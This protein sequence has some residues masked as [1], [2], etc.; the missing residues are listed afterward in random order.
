MTEYLKP[1]CDRKT[2]FWKNQ[3]NT[4]GLLPGLEGSC[5][6]AT[7]AP[8]G[9]WHIKP[10]RKLPECYVAHTMSAYKGVRNVLEHNTRL[11]KAA[12]FDEKV[13]LLND[14]FA[15]FRKAEMRRTEAKLVYRIHWSGD[16]F[17][18]DY[19]NALAKAIQ[20]NPD[21]EFWNYTRSLF[22]VPV[23]CN[24]ENLRLYISLD[25]V[26]IQQGTMTY[27]EHK[28][29]KNHLQVCYMSDIDDFEDHMQ[30]AHNILTEENRLRESM[31]YKPKSGDLP[32]KLTPCPVDT[33][34]LKLEMGCAV[35]KRCVKTLPDPVFFKT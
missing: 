32:R 14:E 35:C 26:N 4:Y 24:I 20:D 5:P 19:A 18:M 17:D 21:I 29:T 10:G 16:I 3:K 12:S 31:G 15:R 1:T 33:G 22:A 9:C 13:R 28:T 7:T 23:L 27:V 2:K 8:G 34:K 25:P 6:G 11:L 30:R